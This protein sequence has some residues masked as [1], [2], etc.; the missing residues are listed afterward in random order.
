[1]KK[2]FHDL[3]TTHTIPVLVDFYADW[4][5]P[6]QTMAPVLKALATELDSKI[7]IIKIDVEKNQPIVQ[8]Y[9]VQNIPAFILFYQGNALWRQSGAMSMDDLKHRIEQILTKK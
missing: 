7:K 4:C 1:M 2:S 8:K 3:I 9:Q 6:C 5:A